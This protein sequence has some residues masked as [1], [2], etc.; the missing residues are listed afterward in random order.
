MPSTE[1]NKKLF[2]SRLS[3]IY[4]NWTSA[5]SDSVYA[6]LAILLGEDEPIRKGTCFQQ[7][8]LGYEFPA[9]LLLFTKD[10][11]YGFCSASKAKILAAVQDAHPTVKLTLFPQ[12]GKKEPNT[13]SFARVGYLLKEKHGGKTISE[14]EAALSKAG[15][16]PQQV[17]ITNSCL[18]LPFCKR[19]RRQIIETAGHLTATLLKHY[20]APKLESIL[21]RESK[22]PHSTVSATIE[23]RLGSGEG[24]NAKGPDMKVWSNYAGYKKVDWDSVEMVYPPI[25]QSASSGFDLRINSESTD[26]VIAHKGVLLT[27]LGLKYR[28]YCVHMGRTFIVDPSKEQE[29]HYQLLLAMQKEMVS[30]IKDGVTCREVYTHATQYLDKERPSIAKNFVKTIGFVVSCPFNC[31]LSLMAMQTGVEFRD[32]T[33]K[34]EKKTPAAPR[35]NGTPKQV[36]GKVLRGPS[37]RNDEVQASN[38]AKFREHQAALRA[39]LHDD[40]LA[41]YNEDGVPTAGT[42][43]KGWKKFQSYKGEG[44][45]P[46]QVEKCRIVVDRKAQTVILPIHGFAV[47]F[48]I[49]TIKNASKNEEGEYAY[50][51]INFQTPGQAGT[52][53]KDEQIPT[54]RLFRSVSYRSTDTRRF[55]DLWKQITDLKREATKREQQKKE[56]ADVVEQDTLVEIRGRK[57]LRYAECNMRPAFDGKRY[58]G[59]VEIHENGVK[60]TSH[61]GQK[62]DVL[63]NNVK[64]L[65]FQPC[66][67]ELLV[68]IHLN[69][70]TPIIIGK[71]KTFDVQFY[72]EASDMAFDET[73]NRKRKHQTKAFAEKLAEASTHSSLTN[74]SIFQRP[75]DTLEVD[76]PFRD[77]SFEGVPHRSAVRLQPTTDCLVQLTD[78][79]FTVV[80]LSEIEIASLERMQYGLKHFDMRL[81]FKDFTKPIVQ[82][83]SI[84]S[85][86]L[87]DV[88]NWLDSVDIAIAESQ[89]NLNWGPIMK[90]INE[91]PHAFFQE[92]GWSTF[93]GGEGEANNSD[94]EESSASEFGAESEDFQESSDE[95]SDFSDASGSSGG[96]DFDDDDDSDGDDWDEL[97]KKAAKSDKKKKEESRNR[98]GDSD[99]EDDRPKK[100]APP[101]KPAKSNGTKGKR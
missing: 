32:S 84:D 13:S 69:L 56:M 4:D 24:D 6:P 98:G 9:T 68:I 92:G 86:S 23:A 74:L 101:K 16:K 29:A 7:W 91:N 18:R 26:D 62:L 81:V 94:S 58:M 77:L 61:S 49:N 80:D 20:V 89:L 79:P 78:P 34:K 75:G 47:P 67:H 55:D 40:G 37:R 96:S 50:L 57:P 44:A 3:R 63:F 43:G 5:S 35:T 53:R 65:F 14:W 11:V 48:H 15:S 66:D 33:Y 25:I 76:I 93:L 27:S 90:H 21:D 70:K 19:P 39:K 38:I 85:K 46:S 51:R 2:S 87:E 59:E 36:G 71:K 100:K 60:Y 73:G 10:A 88:K 42:E 30:F 99:D 12:A 64:H 28:S 8:L 83:N 54:P 97:E 82:I 52:I 95:A 31:R 72:K 45:L 41:K 1:L 17:D 22:T